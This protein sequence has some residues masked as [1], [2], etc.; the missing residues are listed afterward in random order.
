[1]NKVIKINLLV[2]SAFAAS[3][4]AKAAEFYSNTCEGRYSVSALVGMTPNVYVNRQEAN[5][6]STGAFQLTKIPSFSNQFKL[7]FILQGELGYFV[8]NDWEVFYDFDWTHATGKTHSFSHKDATFNIVD[9]SGQQ[10]FSNFNGYGNYLGTRFYVT[11]APFP[12]KPFFGFKIGFMTRGAV[13]ATQTA[14]SFGT[15][16]TDTITYFKKDTT[17]SG[18]LQLGLDWQFT[19][20]FSCIFKVEVI[21]TG[22]RKSGIIF[23]H[24]PRTVVKAGNATMQLSIPISLGARWTF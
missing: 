17:I 6:S 21:G 12:I 1:M 9:V 24:P 11:F 13:K 14:T 22:E 2:L 20:N 10:K 3:S 7:P 8:R 15:T 19:Q 23:N 5:A 16:F 4:C 18:G